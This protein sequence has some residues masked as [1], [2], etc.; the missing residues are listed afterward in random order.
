MRDVQGCGPIARVQRLDNVG[1]PAAI[2]LAFA[3][4]ERPLAGAIRAV[5]EQSRAF[6][7]VSEPEL[8][9]KGHDGWLELVA[10]G[11]TFDLTGLA[12]AAS[13]PLPGARHFFGLGA[14]FDPAALEALTIVPGPHLSGGKTMLPVLRCLAWLGASLS[15]LP[16]VAAVSWHGANAYC[17]PE[18]YHSG[19]MRW[20]TGGVFP[21]LGLAAL[22][23]AAD[24]GLQSEGLALFTG[25]EIVLAPEL[26]QERAEGAKIALRLINW[27]VD[28]G[29]LEEPG[30][31]KGPGGETLRL[32]PIAT[33]RIIKVTASS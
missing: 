5:A 4:G 23:P 6:A 25:Q 31:L 28:H 13:D 15:R 32:E 21:G 9:G 1:R 11:L 27:L 14:D 18:F 33:Q 19:V 12:P 16:G 2:S 8:E 3:A 10:S 29:K 22:L 7:V 20:I 17:A 24:G 30:L 26:A